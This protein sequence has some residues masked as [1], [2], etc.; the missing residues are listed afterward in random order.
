MIVTAGTPRCPSTP[1]PLHHRWRLPRSDLAPLPISGPRRRGDRPNVE[2]HRLVHQG[3]RWYLVAWDTGR[4]DWRTFRVDRI[5]PRVTLGYAFVARDPPSRD[6]AAYV[7]RGTAF[8][9]PCRAKVKFFAPADAVAQRVPPQYGSVEPID[10]ATCYLLTGA[11]TY[12]QLAIHL[13]WLGWDFE[14]TDPPELVEQVR[15]LASRYAR[16]T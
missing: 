11:P 5:Q 7:S 9:P 15:C 2:P 16:A 13:A 3:Y 4:A 6:L 12:D 14:V 1:G 10:E 8:A